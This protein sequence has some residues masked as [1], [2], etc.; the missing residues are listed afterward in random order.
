M[1]QHGSGDLTADP[2]LLLQQT[3]GSVELEPCLWL[4]GLK[5]PDIPPEALRE[6]LAKSLAPSALISLE[7]RPSQI[8]KIKVLVWSISHSH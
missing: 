1:Y 6:R 5:A 2:Q 4:L 8:Q 3:P 7:N